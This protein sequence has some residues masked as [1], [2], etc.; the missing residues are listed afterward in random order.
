MWRAYSSMIP[1]STAQRQRPSAAAML[2]QRIVA[3][4]VESGRLGHEPCG[5]VHL[6]S[7]CVPRLSNHL[8]FG[9]STIEIAVTVGVGAEQP[10]HVLSR[11]QHPKRRTLHLGQMSHQPQQRH[12]RRLDG[13]PRQ[14][15]RIKT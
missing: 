12:R 10:G 8:G 1:T 4:D 7:P 5:E 9:I 3:G 6:R 13:T 14:S 2:I 11:H 15:L